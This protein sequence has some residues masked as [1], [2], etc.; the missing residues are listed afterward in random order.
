[1]LDVCLLVLGLCLFWLLFVLE[2]EESFAK[3]VIGVIL[4][5][6]WVFVFVWFL[7]L[8]MFFLSAI[9]VIFCFVILRAF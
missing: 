9:E 3:T 1:M 8:L 4:F 2:Y 6:S 5:C 7:V